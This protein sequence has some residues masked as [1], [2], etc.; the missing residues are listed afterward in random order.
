MCCALQQAV[1][2]AS[3]ELLGD[4][5]EVI[6]QV[7]AEEDIGWQQENSA[8]NIQSMFRARA[9]RRRVEQVPTSFANQPLVMCACVH[10]KHLTPPLPSRLSCPP[11]SQGA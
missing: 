3:E 1:A 8:S 10:Y 6:A 5:L 11:G 2:E 9:A 7:V 4:L